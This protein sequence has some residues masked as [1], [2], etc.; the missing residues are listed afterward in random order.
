VKCIEDEI[1]FE[2]PESWEWCRFVNISNITSSRRIFQDEYQNKGIPFYRTKEIVELS[3]GKD[4]SVELFIPN[5]RYYEIKRTNDVPKKN[6]LL[7]SAVGT[8]GIIWVIPDNREFY[9]KDGNL[10][11]VKDLEAIVPKFLQYFLNYEFAQVTSKKFSGSAYNALTIEKLKQYLIPIPS[12]SEQQRIVSEI[13]R[14]F[15]FIDNIDEN[16][17][18]LEQIIKQ[19]KS[20]V[21]DLAIHGKLVPQDPND[22]PASGLLEKIKTEQKKAGKKIE[23]T[24]DNSHYKPFEI[25]ESWVWCKLEDIGTTNI[26]LTYKPSEICNNGVPVL[27]ST[28]IKGDKLDLSDLVRVSSKL[29]NNLI[30]NQGDILICARNGSRSLVGKCALIHNVQEITTFGAFMAIYRSVCNEFIFRILNSRYFRIRLEEANSTQINQLTQDMLKNTLIPLPSL[31]EQK[32]IVSQ[33]E[34]IF[35]TLDSI[36]NNL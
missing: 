26:G 16:K 3:Q 31:S 17:L 33:I 6:E 34:T 4:I 8:I 12:L 22:E 2:I 10:I 5:E 27:R 13:E 25:P 15:S 9:F 23:N 30:V 36:Q 18:S 14:L 7:I 35:K 1:S 29:A 24:S 32:R 11:W 21:L 20:K 19:A 28:N